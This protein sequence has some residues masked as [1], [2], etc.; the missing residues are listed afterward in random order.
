MNYSFTLER[1][2]NYFVLSVQFMRVKEV[3]MVRGDF[4]PLT[5]AH[6][7]VPLLMNK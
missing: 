7:L 2:S 3:K 1:I 5:L 6:H 4:H